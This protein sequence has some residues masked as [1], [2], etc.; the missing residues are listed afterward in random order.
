VPDD[1]APHPPSDG[2]ESSWGDILT[3]LPRER[4]VHGY[5]LLEDIHKKRLVI[6][7]DHMVS[8][9]RVT[10]RVHAYRL[11]AD[12]E[13]LIH[14]FLGLGFTEAPQDVGFYY[15][16][17]GATIEAYPLTLSP[18]GIAARLLIAHT[19]KRRDRH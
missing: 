16:T 19:L 2:Q 11:T 12:D 9:L 1:T 8:V 7:G 10:D 17:E 3:V 6:R 14:V 18:R 15:A 4:L 5:D 13:S